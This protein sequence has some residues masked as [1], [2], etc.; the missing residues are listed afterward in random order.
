MLSHTW[1]ASTSASSVKII[2]RLLR[3]LGLTGYPFQ[4]FSFAG[5][6]VSDGCSTSGVTEVK[7]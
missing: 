7:S 2:L 5:I 3:P 1:T 6:L 4:L